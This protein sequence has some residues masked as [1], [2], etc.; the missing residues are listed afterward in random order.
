MKK[1][2]TFFSIII[3]IIL[4]VDAC[5]LVSRNAEKN[6]RFKFAK[7]YEISEDNV[8]VYRSASEAAEIMENGTGVIF[9]GF[10]ECQWCKAYVP[11]LNEV[12][13]EIGLDKIY[14]VDIKKDRD[15]NTKAYQSI[16]SHLNSNLLNDEEGNKRIYVPNLT[17]VVNGIVV[18]NNNIT[19]MET[20]N[21]EEYWTNERKENFKSNIKDL[22]TPFVTETCYMCR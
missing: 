21:P 6:D 3:V 20:G 7:E 12:A 19:S 15:K 5:I 2:I 4:I 1:I 8:F 16:V 22:L 13:I 9:F 11:M 17:I 10:S 14:Y 18:G